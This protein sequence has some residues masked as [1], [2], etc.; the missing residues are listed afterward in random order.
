[1]FSGGVSLWGGPSGNLVVVMV[2]V[3]VMVVFMVVV[4]VVG[5]VLVMVV[6]RVVVVVMV[7]VQ[8]AYRWLWAGGGF[9]GGVLFRNA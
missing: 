6:V 3:I 7:V 9:S 5:M 1:M 8:S 4:M 2:V